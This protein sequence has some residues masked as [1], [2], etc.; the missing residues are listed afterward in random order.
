VPAVDYW[1]HTEPSRID[2]VAERLVQLRARIALMMGDIV[3]KD[4]D[5]KEAAER[6]EAERR[7][8]QELFDSL[9]REIESKRKK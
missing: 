6:A 3:G 5:A 8:A 7:K 4:E 1:P 9:Q 2:A